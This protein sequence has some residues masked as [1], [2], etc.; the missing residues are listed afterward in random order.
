MKL[1]KE[2]VNLEVSRFSGCN[3]VH[4]DLWMGGAP[5]VGNSVSDHFDCLI[6]MANEYQPDES[7]FC[8]IDVH[9]APIED[10]PLFKEQIVKAFHAASFAKLHLDQGKKVLITCYAGLNRSGLVC[11]IT[12]CT[13][14]NNSI[15]LKTAINKIRAARGYH[16]LH[17]PYF[18]DF[19]EKW[20]KSRKSR[21]I[22]TNEAIRMK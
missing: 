8:D 22:E 10:G 17:N 18:L 2:S 12:A 19:L 21:I 5:P 15:D 20:D 6:L 7:Y 1:I 4:G 13:I 3:R 14:K 16:A 11:A 9:H